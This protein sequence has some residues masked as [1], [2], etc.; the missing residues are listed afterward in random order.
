MQKLSSRPALTQGV[1]AGGCFHELLVCPT[2]PKSL[3]TKACTVFGVQTVCWLTP[4]LFGEW[5]KRRWIM[6]LDFSIL[7]VGALLLIN[8]LI[9]AKG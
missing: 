9:K 8:L 6:Y 1:N 2:A 4:V 3:P 5:N 7:V